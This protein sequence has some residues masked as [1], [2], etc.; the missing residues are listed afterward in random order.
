VCVMLGPLGDELWMATGG[1]K[2]S[3][4]AASANS[5]L[6]GE[7]VTPV[8]DAG[9]LFDPSPVAERAS[10]HRHVLDCRRVA[11]EASTAQ[12]WLS[13]NEA[14]WPV[15]MSAAA[16]A[17][18]LYNNTGS[19]LSGV[20]RWPTAWLL[21][22]TSIVM[23]LMCGRASCSAESAAPKGIVVDG[24]A[25]LDS[26]MLLLLSARVD[27]AEVVRLRH[28]VLALVDDLGQLKWWRK[29]PPAASMKLGTD[30][31]SH[32]EASEDVESQAWRTIALDTIARRVFFV[33][34]GPEPQV[35]LLDMPSEW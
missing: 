30:R 8:L 16:T 29:L 11:G 26:S 13:A 10:F 5:S 23:A 35:A 12:L 6:Q 20:S 3:L 27:E 17:V 24:I 22:E 14:R 25:S 7:S 2:F 18:H 21:G 28:Q 9:E 15:V 33:S 19:G 1:A 32:V 34:A 31:V 4:Y